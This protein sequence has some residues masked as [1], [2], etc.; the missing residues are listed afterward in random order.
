VAV[1]HPDTLLDERVAKRV[2]P[3]REHAF[4][5]EGLA[6]DETLRVDPAA[7]P[8]VRG[9]RPPVAV[10]IDLFLESA[11][12]H[13]AISGW[14]HRGHQEGVVTP[15][16]AA[17]DRPEAN[18]PSPLVT[19]HSRRRAVFRSPQ[20]SRPNETSGTSAMDR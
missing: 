12:K 19:S 7:A 20:T 8:L 1:C 4:E 10:V 16:V 5:P 2:H 3:N 14:G 11:C 15:G 9:H 18:P 13:N 17:G 6:V